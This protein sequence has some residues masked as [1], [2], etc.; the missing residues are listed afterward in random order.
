M[1]VE[2]GGFL[3]A[4]P[5]KMIHVNQHVIRANIKNGTNDPCVTVKCG[6]RNLYGVRADVDGPTSVV[7]NITDGLSC[8]AK[9]WIETTAAVNVV[10]NV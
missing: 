6:N 2:Q 8:G 7:Q 9:V 5:R 4:G 10:L 3:P 1:T